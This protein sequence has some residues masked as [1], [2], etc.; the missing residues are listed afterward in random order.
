MIEHYDDD[1]VDPITGTKSEW[2]ILIYLT[3]VEDGVKAGETIFYPAGKSAVSVDLLRGR[4]VLHK[5]GRECMPHEGAR[6]KEGQKWILRTDLMF[7]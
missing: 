2:T 5:H 3:G 6:V 1:T 7:A 4:A